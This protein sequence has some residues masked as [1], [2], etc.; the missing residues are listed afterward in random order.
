MGQLRE[1]QKAD[2][3]KCLK[4][5]TTPKTEQPTLDAII[6]DGAVIVQMLPP[7]TVRTFEGYCQTVFGP[8]IE[9]QL[10]SE[11]CRSGVGCV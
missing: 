6:L 3:V 1:G 5:V 7:G 9:R 2:L 11:A 4:A 10:Q 8:Y